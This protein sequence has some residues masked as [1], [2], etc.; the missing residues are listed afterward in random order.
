M[1]VEIRTARYFDYAKV[2][3][4]GL[5]PVATSVGMPKF[6]MPYEIGAQAGP[7]APYGLLKVED[8]DE[9]TSLYVARLEGF[10]VDAIEALL[11]SVAAAYEQPGVVLLCFENLEKDDG[12]W[13]HRAI[14]AEWWQEKT[15]QEVTEL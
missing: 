2:K 6:P 12:A 8:R 5:V 7:L 3:E 14:F 13:C 9:F 4:S 1:T 11:G 15:G 10:G